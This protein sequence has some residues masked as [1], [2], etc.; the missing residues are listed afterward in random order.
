MRMRSLFSDHTRPIRCILFA[1]VCALACFGSISAQITAYTH[2]SLAPLS[3]DFSVSASGT[4]VPVYAFDRSGS[5]DY[6]FAHFAFSGTA[7][8]TVTALSESSI[9]TASV[10]PLAFSIGTTVSG[11]TLSFSLTQSRYLIVK[12]DSLKELVIA[13]DPPES[14]VPASSGAGIYNVVTYGADNTGSETHSTVVATTSAFQS[15]INDAS[16]NG[17]GIVY[18]PSGV[19]TV[20]NITLQSN[21]TLYLNS[22]AT[23]RASKTSSDFTQNFYVAHPGDN[24][25]TGE[26]G[27]WFIST[28][29]GSSNITM[30]GRGVID[31]TGTYLGNPSDGDL[32]DDII[33]PLGTTNFTIDGIVGWDAGFW[34]LTPDQSS[35]VTIT[36]YKGMQSL[37]TFQ[38]DGMDI[39][40]DQGVTVQH[41]IIVSR[42][43][44]YSTKTWGPTGIGT[45]WPYSP[46]PIADVLFQDVVAWT[47]DGAFKIGEGIYQP[48]TNI[49]F[50]H[51]LRPTS[52]S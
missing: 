52:T 10:S 5:T 20:A 33:V 19:Y 36:N 6:Y 23:V 24:S 12:I 28:A 11:N 46:E 44:C 31:G 14:N 49:T 47:T 26:W 40:E 45:Q 1:F 21:V 18:V 48:Q 35:N 22:G 4:S 27:T 42:D 38:D 25:S 30:R 8:I 29:P 17:G 41:A 7:N 15:A 13:A 3:T 50:D 32:L 9:T 37:Q 51:G 34:A 16:T 2:T 43:D 39:S